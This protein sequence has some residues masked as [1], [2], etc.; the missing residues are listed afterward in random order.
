MRLSEKEILK[1][2]AL[3]SGALPPSEQLEIEKR[4]REDPD[5]YKAAQEWK[6]IITEGFSP[7]LAEQKELAEIKK[8]ILIYAS[9][10]ETRTTDEAP[11][12]KGKN[13][14]ERFV[15]RLYFGLAAAAVILLLLWLSPIKQMIWP[16]NPYG[17]FF[18]H[19]PRDNANLSTA[20]DAGRQAYDRKQYRKAYPAL[21]N[22]V[23]S[24]GDSLNLIYA[25][26]AALG[27]KQAAKAIPLF[28]LLLQSENW[29]LYQSEIQWYLALA[30]LE[31]DEVDKAAELLKNI[32][33]LN[34][35]YTNEAKEL[36]ERI[37]EN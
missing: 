27:S 21:L 14:R 32:I 1:L 31:E 9:A 34:G 26:V 17:D 13:K 33:R 2:E 20:T 10:D 12:L 28:E 23:T 11:T 30:Y 5:F 16:Q 25:G 22:S 8:R 24:E 37:A 6:L 3:W 19:L 35:D 15:R 36:E 18:T 7:P 4:L 29:T